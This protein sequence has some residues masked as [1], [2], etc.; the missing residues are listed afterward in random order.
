MT[1]KFMLLAIK[2][3]LRGAKMY[4]EVPVG[5]VIVKNGEVIAKAHNK[6]QKTSLSTK[7][8]EI[9]ALEKAMKKV[10]DWRLNECELYVTLEPCPMC[11]G[12]IIN[13]RVG[14]VYYGAYDSKAGCV[15]SLCNLL[16]DKR[17]NHNPTVVRG[18]IMEAECARILTDYFKAKR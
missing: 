6:K 16:E 15:G 17:F 18:G 1:D 13:A 2:E 11:A 9:I 10:G 12:A 7:H 14:K 4:D 8:A 3:A 5:A